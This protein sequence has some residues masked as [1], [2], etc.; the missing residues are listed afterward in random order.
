ME[1][2]DSSDLTGR[3]YELEQAIWSKENT[4]AFN[5]ATSIAEHENA[6]R[7]LSREQQVAFVATYLDMEVMNGGFAQWCT[8]LAGVFT[9]EAIRI[10]QEIGATELSSLIESLTQRLPVG[11]FSNLQSESDMAYHALTEAHWEF[12]D[13]CGEKYEYELQDDFLRLACE[14]AGIEL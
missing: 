11:L 9:G 4:D 1:T 12:L 8:N 13:S 5:N 2:P 3:L 10:T 7:A 14:A 6:L